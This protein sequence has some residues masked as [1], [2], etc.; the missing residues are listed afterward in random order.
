[1]TSYTKLFSS[2]L[3]STVWAEPHPTRIVWITM[4]AMADQYGVVSASVPGLARAACVTREEAEAAL[5]TFTLPDPDSR[6][7]EHEGRR[8]AA[9]DGGWR[10]LNHDKYRA[11]LSAEDKRAKDAERQARFRERQRQKALG[12]VTVGVTAINHVSHYI[13]EDES[14][15]EQS[16]AQKHVSAVNIDVAAS[17]DESRDADVAASVPGWADV[18]A[19]RDERDVHSFDAVNGHRDF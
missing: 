18:D 3:H 16:M 6:S 17:R 13:R 5:A 19:E 9:V 15:E 14:R 12:D 2:I 8:I 4:L 1:M 7:Q 10:L 11:L